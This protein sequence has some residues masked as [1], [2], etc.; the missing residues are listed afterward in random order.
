MDTNKSRAIEISIAVDCAKPKA[1][2]SSLGMASVVF[3]RAVNVGGHQKFQPSI[4]AKALAEFGV[5]NVGAAG[6][7]VVREK[8]SQK[9]LLTEIVRRLPF[10]PDL[11]ICSASE[12]LD[13]F[14]DDPFPATPP[15]KDVRKFLTVMKKAPRALPALPLEKPVGAKWEVRLIRIEGRFALSFWRPMGRSITYP[16]AVVEKQFGIPA[17]TRSWNTITTVCGILNKEHAN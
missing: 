8:V 11:M 7:L 1:G 9:T 4:L 15:G 3:L 2:T 13:L 16:N 12:I 14:G 5:V 17:T 10:E 6:T